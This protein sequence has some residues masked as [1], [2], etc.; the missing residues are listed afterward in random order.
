LP[1]ASV[2]VADDGYFLRGAE[3]AL[4]KQGIS[5]EKITA[6][7]DISLATVRFHMKNA[8]Q[9]TGTRSQLELAALVRRFETG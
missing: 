9:K 7:L 5:P 1:A 6:K 3:P 4:E 8:F 2:R